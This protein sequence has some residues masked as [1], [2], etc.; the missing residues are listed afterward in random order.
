MFLRTHSLSCSFYHASVQN[1]HDVTHPSTLDV[2]SLRVN[3]C[4]QNFLVT[5]THRPGTRVPWHLDI[6]LTLPLSLFFHRCTSTITIQLTHQHHRDTDQDSP[7]MEPEHTQASGAKRRFEG[8]DSTESAKKQKTQLQPPAG[9]GVRLFELELPGSFNFSAL[10]LGDNGSDWQFIQRNYIR[11]DVTFTWGYKGGILGEAAP[12]NGNRDE[13]CMADIG[14]VLMVGRASLEELPVEDD[15]VLTLC[16]ILLKWHRLCSQIEPNPKPLK[17]LFHE[18][19][20]DTRRKASQVP[21]P[22][23]IDY[24]GVQSR[25]VRE[26]AM[27][28]GQVKEILDKGGENMADN[29]ERWLITSSAYTRLIRS[30]KIELVSFEWYFHANENDELERIRVEQWRMAMLAKFSDPDPHVLCSMW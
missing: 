20:M 25:V 9:G 15:N 26:R 4:R 19:A 23:P 22:L 12:F 14:Y 7:I 29:L 28:T 18:H 10:V 21:Q 3:Q 30:D 8:V 1:E 24:P 11:G 6:F 13:S 16:A 2:Y 27:C 17:L 5:A